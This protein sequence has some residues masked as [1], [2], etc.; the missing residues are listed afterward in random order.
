MAKRPPKTDTSKSDAKRVSDIIKQYQSFF[1]STELVRREMR[2]DMDFVQG[3]RKQWYPQDIAKLESDEEKRPILSFNITQAKVNFVTGLQQEREADYRYFPRGTEDEAF[4]RI[5]TAQVKY[6]MDRCAGVH[7]EA[8]QFRTGYIT[9]ASVLEV[10]HSYDYTDD[11]LEGDVCLT[12]LAF[13]TWYCDPLSRRYDRCDARFQGKLMW[14]SQEAAAQAWPEHAKRIIGMGDWFPHDPLTTGVPDQLLNELYDRETGRVRVLQHWYKVPVTATLVVNSAEMDPSKAIIRMKNGKDAEAFIQAQADQAGVAAAAP[15]SIVQTDTFATL[16]NK[17]T[18]GM[19]TLT[20]VNEGDRFI[21]QVRADAGASVAA[22]FDI[23]T[24][25]ATSMRVAHLTGA[26]LLSDTPSPYDDDW[27]YPFSPFFAYHD[28]EDFG[29]IKG[30]VRDIKDP[31]REINWHHSTIVDT[32]ARAPKGATWIEMASIGGDASKLNELKKKLPRAGFVGTYTGSMPQYWP[33]GS[34]SPGDLAMMEIASDFA[35]VITGTDNLQANPQQKTVSGRA[36]GARFAGGVVSLGT[37]LQ[38]WQRTKEYTGML[39]AKRVQQ[40]HS[41]EKM[42][43]ILGQEFRMKQIAGMDLKMEMPPEMVYEQ[44]KTIKDLS[45]DVV[46]G[47]QDPTTTAREANLNRMMQMMAAGF[48]IPP[49][50]IVEASDLP[51]KEEITAA[52]QQQGMQQP[53]ADLAKVLSAGQGQ[54]ADGVNTSQ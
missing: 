19:M 17:E 14:Y 47:F 39:L 23:V 37:I 46:V 3:G 45:Y 29:S 33:P 34:F 22:Q 12:N 15:F 32:M 41:P 21:E 25:Q 38:H 26:E 24:R 11:F 2:E 10:A 54:G 5:M 53:N 50:L 13:N 8:E 48:P 30:G 27:K 31:Q 18:G 16:V 49:N 1:T 4:G 7:E 40:F 9:G 6:I 43:R 20:D 35:G 44:Y 51:Y 28:G 42:N 36:I 52:L